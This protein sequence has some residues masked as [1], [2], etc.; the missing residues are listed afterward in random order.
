MCVAQR[1]LGE[2]CFLICLLSGCSIL[3]RKQLEGTRI[4]LVKMYVGIKISCVNSSYILHGFPFFTADIFIY[5]WDYSFFRGDHGF[6]FAIRTPCTP[7]RWEDFNA[8]MSM[9]WEVCFSFHFL[10]F[11]SKLRMFLWYHYQ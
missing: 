11:V 6:D 3:F 5:I 1:Y 8:E 7:V 9:A 4:T 10:W 2:H